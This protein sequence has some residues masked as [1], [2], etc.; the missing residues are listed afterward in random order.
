M[1]DFFRFLRCLGKAL[2]KHGPRGLAGLVPMGADLY[3]AARDALAEYDGKENELCADVQATAQAGPA[4]VKQ[5][6]E[7]IVRQ[8]AA[9]QPTE[10]QAA[11]ATYLTQAPAAMRGRC[12]EPPIHPARPFQRRWRFDGPK[13]CCRCCRHG[14]R[15][16]SRATGRCL[17]LIV[18]SSS[19]SV[20][21]VS[22]KSGRHAIPFSRA[23][24]WWR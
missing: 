17:A 19:C 3:D 23:I 18:N 16:S 5:A 7:T 24:H 11:L 21:A 6:A 2:V 8:V 15:A 4:E 1:P 22:V 12:A 9:D 14:C 20:R 10:A 13:T